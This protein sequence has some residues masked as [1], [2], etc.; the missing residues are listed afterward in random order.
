LSATAPLA[1]PADPTASALG[2]DARAL[3]D[4]QRDV[5]RARATV[6]RITRYLPSPIARALER[7][8]AFLST[9]SLDDP[10]L[11]KSSEWFLDNYYLIRRVA[12]Q[13]S[14]DLPPGFLAR[15]PLLASGNEAGV[16]RIDALASVIVS[17]GKL[18][19]DAATLRSFV[20]AYQE[21]SPLTVAELW[22]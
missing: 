18:A 15:L 7:A 19:I 12:R 22:A 13:T 9:N 1:A 10:A 21:V 16:P 6:A 4:S 20:D 2:A 11:R 5:R 8:R 3:A 17:R 14:E